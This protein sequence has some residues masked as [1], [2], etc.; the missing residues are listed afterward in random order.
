MGFRTLAQKRLKTTVLDDSACGLPARFSS[1]H[2]DF[3]HI[4][5]EEADL[6]KANVTF[7]FSL[8]SNPVCHVLSETSGPGPTSAWIIHHR[9][10][11]S[12]AEVI[13]STRSILPMIYNESTVI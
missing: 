11:V 8:K 2:L 13:G 5:L 6:D 4:P 9:L 12:E 10:T 1:S 3:L 7:G